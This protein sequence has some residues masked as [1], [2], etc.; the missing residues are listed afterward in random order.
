MRALVLTLVALVAMAGSAHAQQ[1]PL[2]T[3]DPET[4]G[5]GRILIEGGIDYSRSADYPV[6]GLEGNLLRLPLLGASIGISSIAELQIDGG[7]YNRLS[8]T[9]RNFSAP[10]AHMVTLTGDSTSSLEDLV[11]GT[12]VRFV[13]ERPGRPSFA[14]RLATKLPMASN[15]SGLGLDTTDFYA[16][17]LVGKTVQ[18]VRMVFNGGVGILADPTRGDLQNDVLTYGASFARAMT[19]AFE[20]VTEVNGRLDTRDGEAPPGTESRGQ[21]RLGVRY[22]VASWRWDA[23]MFF[24]LTEH[25]P[26]LGFAG[27]FTYVFN[28]FTVP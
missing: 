28:A 4:V 15:E 5:A 16:S 18:S 27:G 21:F 19:N 6:S 7:L 17:L 2:I 23:A 1:R 12:K 8:V 20:V 24:G 13:A 14:V 11:L 25:D 10:L 22:T 3:E 26:S 9:S